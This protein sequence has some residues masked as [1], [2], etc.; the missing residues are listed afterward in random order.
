MYGDNLEKLFTNIATQKAKP[1]AGFFEIHIDQT[2]T[3]DNL[4]NFLK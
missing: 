1:T 2:I 3:V 4:V